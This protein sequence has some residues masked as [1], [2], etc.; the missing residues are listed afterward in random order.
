MYNFN[1]SINQISQWKRFSFTAECKSHYSDWARLLIADIVDLPN[2]FKGGGMWVG[3]CIFIF[4]DLT[5][6]NGLSQ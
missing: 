2:A 3:T 1:C 6:L 4:V 5:G